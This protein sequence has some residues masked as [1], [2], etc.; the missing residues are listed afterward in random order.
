VSDGAGR[1]DVILSPSSVI[2]C[3]D[4]A[5]SEPGDRYA[6]R[7]SSTRRTVSV[8]DHAACTEVEPFCTS[9]RVHVARSDPRGATVGTDL[10]FMA[11]PYRRTTTDLF[12]AR[13][14]RRPLA[15]MRARARSPSGVSA[16]MRVQ[17][18]LRAVTGARRELG[19]TVLTRLSHPHSW[20]STGPRE[21]F[22]SKNL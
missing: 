8:H 2:S 19:I 10:A 13:N 6:R 21:K 17:H 7:R 14:S 12:F 16:S 11:P 1:T 20:G 9:F 3:C 15:T 5:F 22:L 4:A 18:D